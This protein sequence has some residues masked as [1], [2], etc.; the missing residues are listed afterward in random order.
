MRSTLE[1][2][3][4]FTHSPTP[5]LARAGKVPCLWPKFQSCVQSMG[6]LYIIVN[7]LSVVELSTTG[8]KCCSD[9][10]HMCRGCAKFWAQSGVD[11]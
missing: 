5:K 2:Q 9:G 7:A 8:L 10:N 3:P 6:S 1:I 4:A 11:P